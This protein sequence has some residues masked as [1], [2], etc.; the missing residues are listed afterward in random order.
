MRFAL[1]G[2]CLDCGLDISCAVVRHADD[3]ITISKLLSTV[4][5][6]IPSDQVAFMLHEV[7]EGRL[8]CDESHGFPVE[9]FPLAARV[10]ER[11]HD[12]SRHKR[13]VVF[14]LMESPASRS[15]VSSAIKLESIGRA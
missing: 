10:V 6:G 11:V 9:Q 13:G 7:P 12:V 4:N 8:W 15:Q 5:S 1:V 3:V 2:T 14:H